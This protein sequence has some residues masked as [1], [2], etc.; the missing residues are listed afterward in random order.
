VTQISKIASYLFALSGVLGIAITG[1]IWRSLAR[2]GSFKAYRQLIISILFSAGMFMLSAGY[3][4]AFPFV[5]T[6]GYIALS[7][8]ALGGI[9]IEF[10]EVSIPELADKVT[11]FSLLGIPLLPALVFLVSWKPFF[12]L[13]LALLNQSLWYNALFTTGLF[14]VWLVSFMASRLR[15]AYMFWAV[16]FVFFASASITL[17]FGAGEIWMLASSILYLAGTISYIY[18]WVNHG[19]SS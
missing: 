3:H 11:L 1:L 16:T 4:F 2:I 17:R 14:F 8:W 7:F 9:W 15:T 13:N 5:K 19:Q 18:T 6:A 10:R 12:S